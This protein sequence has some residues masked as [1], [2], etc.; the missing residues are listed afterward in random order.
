MSETDLAASDMRSLWHTSG[1]VAVEGEA[2]SVLRARF[3]V[4]VEPMMPDLLRYFA[5]RVIPR[6][7]A[8]D[9]LSETL[10]VLWQRRGKLP[11]DPEEQRA[12]AYGIA[13][14]VLS[15][16]Q[17]KQSR[18]AALGDTYLLRASLAASVPTD[19][20]PAAEQALDALATLPECDRELIR[21]VVW[22]GFGVGQAGAVLGMKDATARS[23]YARAKAR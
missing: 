5:R 22:D 14:K 16:H 2:P 19:L 18:R 10:L 9:L 7:D 6:E 8:A 13:R 1:P 11:Q 20:S 4:I 23:R 3:E 12:W 21:L 17:R 15:N